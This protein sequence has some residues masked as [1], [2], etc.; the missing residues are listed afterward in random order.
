MITPQAGGQAPDFTLSDI[1]DREVRLS[2]YR[3]RKVLLSFFRYASCGGGDH[4]RI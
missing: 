4:R 3:G 2:E 1:L